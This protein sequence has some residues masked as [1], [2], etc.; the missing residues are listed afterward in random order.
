MHSVYHF[1]ELRRI[2]QT[3][4]LNNLLLKYIYMPLLNIYIKHSSFLI[5]FQ[6]YT[7]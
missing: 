1:I 7:L 6:K 5:Y 4:F 3:S 2:E